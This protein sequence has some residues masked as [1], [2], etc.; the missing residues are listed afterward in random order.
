MTIHE[1]YTKC[2]D[3]LA[4]KYT[5]KT[6]YLSVR[7]KWRNQKRMRLLNMHGAPYGEPVQELPKG[8]TLVAFEAQ[9]ILD[10]IN[11]SG[12]DGYADY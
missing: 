6:V 3:A 8:A 2:Q 10:W 9:E 7:K 4:H 1:L 11:T 5:T 12:L